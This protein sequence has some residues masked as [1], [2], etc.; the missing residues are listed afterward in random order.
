[1]NKMASPNKNSTTATAGAA[2]EVTTNLPTVAG[3]I[4][5]ELAG[6]FQTA[7]I[8]EAEFG[9]LPVGPKARCPVSGASRSWL[10]EHDTFGHFLIRVRRKG[11]TR[12]TV[13]VDV[14]KLKSYLRSWQAAN[15]AERLVKGMEGGAP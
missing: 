9:R 12:S 3:R 1:M 8:G 10:I 4:P 14:H 15:E 6:R 2:V 7:P 13:F 5:A 11:H